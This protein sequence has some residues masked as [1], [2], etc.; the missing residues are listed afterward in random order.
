MLTNGNNN[1]YIGSQ[2]VGDESQ[3]IRVG[4]AQTSAYMAGIN[5]AGVSGPA[6]VVDANG[7]LGVTL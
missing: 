3:T 1:I 4:T 2:G 7:R 5:S 6:V